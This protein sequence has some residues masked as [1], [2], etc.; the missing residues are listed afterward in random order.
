MELCATEQLERHTQQQALKCSSGD[1]I[2][3]NNV[4][5][6]L[7]M[8]ALALTLAACGSDNDSSNSS[9][10]SSTKTD[11]GS[12]TVSYTLTFKQ[13]WNKTDFP[14]NF[15]GNP[16]FSP[17]VGATHNSQVVIWRPA[18]K[19]GAKTTDGLKIV[20]ETGS[21][22]KFFSELTAA[23]QTDGHI[24]S[25]FARSGGAVSPGT[26]TQTIKLSTQ[27]P[28]VSAV[29]MIAPSPDWFV[30]IR[31]LNL[32]PNG[33]WLDEVTVNLRLYDADT[34]LGQTFTAADQAGGDRNIHLVTTQANETDFK[35]G[36][37]RNGGAVVG[38]MILKRQ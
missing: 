3:Q 5:K 7:A 2:M 25:V 12:G 15:P 10:N 31:D 38:Q 4:R 22:A 13:T 8:S 1:I 37:H 35:D 36:V 19:G 14:T 20:A 18:G 23:K 33:K 27:F 32:Y 21:T 6:T 16:H 30:G 17:L 28:L 34:D 29:S 11:T 26:Q 9:N 24:D